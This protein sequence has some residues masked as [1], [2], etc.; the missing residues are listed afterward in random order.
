MYIDNEGNALPVATNPAGNQAKP[1]RFL[2]T[3]S[4]SQMKSWV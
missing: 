2:D 3:R 4:K 1:C